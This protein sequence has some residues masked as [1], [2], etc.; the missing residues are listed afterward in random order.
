MEGNEQLKVVVT[1][2][3]RPGPDTAK[4]PPLGNGTEAVVVGKERW[5]ELQRMRAAGQA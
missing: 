2:T 3:D 4:V 1:Q 5:E